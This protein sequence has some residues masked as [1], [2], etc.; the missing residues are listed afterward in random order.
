[1]F[2]IYIVMCTNIFVYPLQLRSLPCPPNCGSKPS[3]VARDVHAQ[4]AAIDGQ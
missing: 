4:D 1:M 2:F 3:R